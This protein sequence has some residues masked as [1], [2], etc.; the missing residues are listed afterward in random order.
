MTELTSFALTNGL[1]VTVEAPAARGFAPTSLHP[2]ISNAEMTLRQALQPVTSAA[3]DASL[4]GGQA[5]AK[6]YEI[7][8]GGSSACSACTCHWLPLG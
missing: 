3:S 7:G 5:F 2:K 8:H 6:L 4:A 1:R